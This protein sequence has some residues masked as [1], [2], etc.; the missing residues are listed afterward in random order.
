MFGRNRSAAEPPAPP[1]TFEAARDS[2]RPRVFSRTQRALQDLETE[3]AAGPAGVPDSAQPV[4]LPVTEEIALGAVLA[5]SGIIVSRALIET[6]QVTVAEVIAAASRSVG[7]R[8]FTEIGLARPGTYLVGEPDLIGGILADPE[9]LSG[10]DIDSAPLIVP[11]ATDALLVTGSQDVAGMIAALAVVDNA[12]ERGE[13]LVSNRPLL[14]GP[15]GWSAADW[16]E[17][18]EL[19]ARAG[20]VDARWAGAV[21]GWQKPL[22]Q[23][24]YAAVGQQVWV[25]ELYAMSDEERTFTL[26]AWTQGVTTALPVAELVSLVTDDGETLLVRWDRLL[27]EQGA[28]LTDTGLVPPRYL[29]E[30]FPPAEW[31]ARLRGGE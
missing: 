23:R 10:F 15:E 16:P 29:T 18:A 14:L 9:L 25:A 30:G 31:V 27:A 3:L 5:D 11:I 24:R 19:A 1:A 28:L 8:E 7:G 2:L 6:W 4:V 26:T 21:Y 13:R 17:D 12:I 22:L 20:Y